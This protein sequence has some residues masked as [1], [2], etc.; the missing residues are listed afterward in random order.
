MLPDLR[1]WSITAA[2]VAGVA[3]ALSGIAWLLHIVIAEGRSLSTA[4]DII[5]DLL[6]GAVVFLTL[7]WLVLR[8]RSHGQK[9]YQ[10]EIDGARRKLD[11]A[12]SN[13][14]QGL[15]LFDSSKR[16][17]VANRR[18]I[19]MYGLSSDVVKPGCAFRDLLHHR[20]DR[21][22]FFG[23]IDQ[24]C[25]NLDAELAQGKMTSLTTQIPGGRLIRVVNQPLSEGGWVATHDDI[26]EQQNIEETL[27]QQKLQLDT[28]LNNMSQGINMFD[29]AGKLVLCN[30]RYRDMYHLPPNVAK[31]GSSIR[32]L[33][34]ARIATGT[35]FSIDPEK[36]AADLLAAMDAKVPTDT[37]LELPDGRVV[38]VHGQLASD[39][40]G[41]VATHEE[42]TERHRLR[43]AQLRAEEIV[44][45]QKVQ[46]D[47]A[48]ENMTHGLCMFDAQGHIMLFN[49]RYAE[50]M[51]QSPEYLHGLSLLDL[52]KHRKST[53]AFHGDPEEFFAHVMKGV[54]EGKTTVRDM[55]RK[56]GIAIRVVDQPMEGGGWVA[57]YEDVTEQRRTERERD[58]NRS[59]LDLIIDNVP[60]AI[61]VKSA[62]DR[63]YVLVNRAGERFWGISR[64]DMIGKTADEV[65]PEVEARKIEARDNELLQ[66]GQM[67]FD[68][69]EILTPCD[70]VRSIFSR[71]LTI[72]D[73]SDAAQYVLGVVDDVTE[74]KAAEARIAHLAHYD[75]LTNLPNRMLFREQLEKEL[76]FVRRGAHLAVHYLDLDNFKS[77]NDTLGH[78]VGDALL[79][80]VA[81]RLRSCLRETDLIARLGGDEFAIVQTE[82]Q[83]P[84]EAGI[85]AQ[86]LREAVTDA[87][88]D[89]GGHQ[90]T[91]DL[92]IGIAL[93]PGDGTEIDELIKHADLALYGAKAEGRAHYRYYE[94]GMNARMKQRRGLEIDLRSAI[95]ND[96][97][98]L[99]Y[100]PLINLQTGAITG[101]EALLRWRHPQRGMIPPLDFIPVAEETGLIHVI[102]DWVLRRACAEAMNW[103]SHVSIAVNVSPVQFRN[104]TLALT[105]ITSLA[106]SGLPARRL[107]LEVTESVLMQ[108][109]DATLKTLHQIHDLGVRISMDDFGTGYSSLSYLRSFPFDKIKIDR[110]FIGDLAKGD[111]AVAIVHAIL[112]LASSLKMTTTAE[113]VETADQQ[114]LLRATGCNEMQGYLFSPPR[115]AAE[116]L[117]LLNSYQRPTK[118][119]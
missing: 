51:G 15:L 97:L 79:K 104:P 8:N 116:I 30:E 1:L 23:D 56:D 55:V 29:A 74:R 83:D 9:Q 22:S 117:Q 45:E 48:L 54:R 78:P 72:R 87:S 62:V 77:I 85:L 40:S 26:T 61:F 66:S 10:Q 21:G 36:Y 49:R 38:A 63:K 18:Y 25:A 111:D 31:P 57:T 16:V 76:S 39:G 70:G 71:R 64:Q 115:P 13:M 44:R 100:Q 33:V 84:K 96:E 114:E 65:F 20:Q 32:D 107:E 41:W 42:I 67:L 90:T 88:Y 75:P 69:R 58:Q 103:P 99:H 81:Q 105:V 3:L 95:A 35:F 68:E 93:A 53:G 60:S 73:K 92:S 37:I 46:L 24:Y 109:N 82:L 43:E 7:G 89:L 102:G 101:C 113:G 27:R 108:N 28:A 5:L 50:L 34:N 119:A 110:S 2:A 14:S 6:I 80:E 11:I 12:V 94:P 59:F 86:R 91:T 47:A 4:E 17:V 19:E 112:N 106:A 118:V 98:E 52:F